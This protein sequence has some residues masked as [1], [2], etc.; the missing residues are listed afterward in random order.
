VARKEHFG[1]LVYDRERG[2]YIPFDDDATTLFQGARE[3]PIAELYPQFEE[4]LTRQSFETFVQLCRSIEL[5]D[6]GGRYNGTFVAPRPLPGMLSAPLRVHLQITNQCLLRCRHCSQDTRDP[7]PN[8]LSLE[9]I[10][11]LFDEMAELGTCQVNLGG[12]EP[13][14]RPDLLQIVRH[15]RSRGLSVSISTTGTS[16]NRVLARKIAELGLKSIRVSFDGAAEKSYDYYRGLK[17]SYRK[18]MRGIKTLRE[19]FAKTPIAL[20]TTLMRPNA[21]EILALARLVSKLGLNS[22]SL[23][24]VKPVGIGAETP[25]LWLSAEEGDELF[26]KL[27]K[28]TET[29]NVPLKMAHFPYKGQQSGSQAFGYRCLGANLFVFVSANGSVAPCSFT[30]RQFPAGNIRRK[31][32]RQIWAESEMFR[33]FRQGVAGPQACA[34]CMRSASASVPDVKYDAHAFVMP[35]A[36]AES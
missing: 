2:D 33:K 9:E 21:S 7:L 36:T 31:S 22:W 1:A 28:I 16:V 12:G 10:Q 24:F 23:D 35:T 29:T 26:K 4:R 5:L 34:F 25:N 17:G 32:L 11:K 3:R 19:V 30:C 6:A 14:L 27:G 18:A 20:H 13:F 8:E 15:A